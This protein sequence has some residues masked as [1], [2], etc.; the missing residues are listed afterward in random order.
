[1]ELQ[2]VKNK[3]NGNASRRPKEKDQQ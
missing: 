2:A 3:A 1:V